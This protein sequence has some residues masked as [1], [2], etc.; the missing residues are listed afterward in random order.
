M[1]IQGYVFN[2]ETSEA[3]IGARVTLLDEDGNK[4]SV[5]TQTDKS[6]FFFLDD[7]FIQS[8]DFILFEHIGFEKVKREATQ[9]EDAKILMTKKVDFLPTNS[10]DADIPLSPTEELK[11]TKNNTSRNLLIFGTLVA[12]GIV[13][14]YFSK[15]KKS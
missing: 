3:L 10:N 5:K 1:T 7:A 14:Y 4:T 2:I 12:V 8:T 15:N 6:G 9:L 11:E 13:A